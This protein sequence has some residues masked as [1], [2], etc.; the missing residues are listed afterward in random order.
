MTDSIAEVAGL[1]ELL[2]PTRLLFDSQRG[3]EIA[4]RFSGCL[5]PEKTAKMTALIS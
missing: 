5:E 1:T 4:Q 3:N 2:D